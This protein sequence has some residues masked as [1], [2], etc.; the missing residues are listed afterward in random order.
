MS[1]QSDEDLDFAAD[2][3]AALTQQQP[4]PIEEEAPENET[5]EEQEERL[6]RREGRRFVAKEEKKAE[7]EAEAEAEPKPEGEQQQAAAPKPEKR[8][9]WYKDEYGDWGKLPENF[10]NA[11]R[12]QERHAAQ[13]IEKH[14]TAAKA[15]EPVNKALEPYMQQLQAS[16]VSGPQYVSNLIEADKYLRADPVAA[17]NWLAQSYLGAGWDIQA[18]AEW[19]AQQGYQPQK[20]DPVK[21]ELEQLRAEM[22]QLQQAPVRQRQE[23]VNEQIRQWSQ[24]KPDFEAVKP[25]MAAIANQNPQGNLDTWYEQARWAHPEIRERILAEREGKRIAGLKDKRQAGAQTPHGAPMP[26]AQPRRTRN[27][28][29][30]IEADLNEAFDEAGLN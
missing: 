11:L 13:A 10:R 29:W 9:T 23:A 24:D 21:Q 27:K 4:A 20:I 7:A 6:Y 14:S 17:I 26:N 15:W 2:L 22:Q 12:E 5:A 18:L 16:G 25:Y 28:S 19:Q 30:D 8:P 3:E 1:T